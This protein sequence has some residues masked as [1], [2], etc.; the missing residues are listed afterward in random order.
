MKDPRPARIRS[1][2]PI[3]RYARRNGPGRGPGPPPATRARGLPGR[4]PLRR[5][6]CSG[7]SGSARHIPAPA[8]AAAARWP[9]AAGR[10]ALPPARRALRASPGGRRG[11][12]APGSLAPP[13]GPGRARRAGGSCPPP[14][15][16]RARPG[17]A[18]RRAGSVLAPGR[19]WA[20][21][22]SAAPCPPRRCGL[23]VSAPRPALRRGPPPAAGLRP[24]RASPAP[25]G[26]RRGA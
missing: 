18:R 15:S 25:R 11:P 5:C 9:C 26:S 7:Q 14:S 12:P 3:P 20:A 2:A 17:P 23:P 1:A 21:P 6:A 19:P 10:G 13:I 16:L 4:S 24:G 22:G 8:V